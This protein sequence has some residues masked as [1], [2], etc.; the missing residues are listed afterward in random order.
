MEK[1]TVNTYKFCCVYERCSF[2]NINMESGILCSCSKKVWKILWCLKRLLVLWSWYGSSFYF[3]KFL[4]FL[5]RFYLLTVEY[6]D[7]SFYT[8]QLLFLLTY[9]WIFKPKE[10][11]PDRYIFEV[12][13][14][15]SFLEGL[16][17]C[18]SCVKICDLCGTATEDGR[19]LSLCM[20][21]LITQDAVLCIFL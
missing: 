21:W 15:C 5:K 10:R 18:W 14:K 1:I 17:S 16:K 13:V 8:W 6:V 19:F 4:G 9:N 20:K 12:Q 2:R 3:C 7:S 11:R